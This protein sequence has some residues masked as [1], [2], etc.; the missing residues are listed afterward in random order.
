MLDAS[1]LLA[2]LAEEQ[3]ADDVEAL[4]DD[5]IMSAVNL[6]EVLQK[7]EQHG[8]D[9]GG[10]SSTSR[11]SASSSP[12]ESTARPSPRTWATPKPGVRVRV[13]R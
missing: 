5:A 9:T 7:P 10:S 2:P 3:G 8:I 4:L 11:R 13:L 6:A 1:A 12:S